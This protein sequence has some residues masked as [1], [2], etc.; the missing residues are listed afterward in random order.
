MFRDGYHPELDELHRATR[1]GR[2]WISALQEREIERTGIKSLKIK[3]NSVFGLLHRGDQEQPRQRAA[4]LHAQANHGGRRT[5]RHAANSKTLKPAS[6]VPRN[7]PSSSS[8][9]FSWT[10]GISC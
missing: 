9:S 1:E 3:Y 10:C 8:N 5:V 2:E 4:G 6:T 7:A